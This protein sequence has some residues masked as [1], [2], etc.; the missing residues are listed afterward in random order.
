MVSNPVKCPR[1][2]PNPWRRL[3]RA[4][5]QAGLSPPRVLEA[6]AC[7]LCERELDAPDRF[8][9]GDPLIYH[10]KWL[11]VADDYAGFDVAA[12]KRRS[13][14]WLAGG[15]GQVPHRPPQLLA[16]TCAAATGRLTDAMGLP[17]ETEN[18]AAPKPR[19]ACWRTRERPRLGLPAF[20][21]FAYNFV[22]RDL[23]RHLWEMRS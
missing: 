21:A 6:T 18:P 14:A 8:P 12:S 5:L 22:M 9:V 3:G 19:R 4:V 23:A 7:S 16:E 13:A 17:L 10:D 1:T 20:N 15:R 11:F 2:F